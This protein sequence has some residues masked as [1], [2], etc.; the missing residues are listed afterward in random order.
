MQ[1]EKLFRQHNFHKQLLASSLAKHGFYEEL[2]L[3]YGVVKVTRAKSGKYGGLSMTILIRN[4]SVMVEALSGRAFSSFLMFSYNSVLLYHIPYYPN[5]SS[6]FMMNLTMTTLGLSNEF[7][8][9]LLKCFFM[10]YS[11]DIGIMVL[12]TN[13]FVFIESF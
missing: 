7:D 1:F 10:S 5:V 11:R 13:E 3:T 4:N 9:K 8:R 2:I 6:K 12:L